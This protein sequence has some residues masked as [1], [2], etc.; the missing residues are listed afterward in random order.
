MLFVPVKRNFQLF[1]RNEMRNWLRN[2]MRGNPQLV[3]FLSLCN[4]EILYKE[5]HHHRHRRTKGALALMMMAV[6]N[7]QSDFVID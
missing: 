5:I 7:I 4:K 3:A 2:W 1:L 6:L